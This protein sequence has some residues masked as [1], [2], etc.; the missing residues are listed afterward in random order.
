MNKNQIIIM[1]IILKNNAFTTLKNAFLS[2]FRSETHLTVHYNGNNG[3]HG[4]ITVT[5]EDFNT[6]CEAIDSNQFEELINFI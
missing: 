5:R 1:E 3:N 2:D 6:I 4:H